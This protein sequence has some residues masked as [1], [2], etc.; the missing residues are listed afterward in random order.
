M[1]DRTHRALEGSRR[2]GQLSVDG[3]RVAELAASEGWPALELRGTARVAVGLRAGI[4]EAH[5][6]GPHGMLQAKADCI[7][8]LVLPA[9]VSASD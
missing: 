2:A 6:H 9:R 4:T 5:T 1:I 3:V 8:A 7:A